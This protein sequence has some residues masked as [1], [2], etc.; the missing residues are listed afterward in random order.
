ME[1]EVY[2]WRVSTELK[3]ALERTARERNTTVAEALRQ[4]STEWIGQ[5]EASSDEEA[6]QRRLHLAAERFIGS[7]TGL[8]PST[9]ASQ[10]IEEKLRRRN[11]R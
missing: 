5:G 2:S 7:L 10:S 8:A 11:A 9:K 6:E 1:T 3:S 4:A